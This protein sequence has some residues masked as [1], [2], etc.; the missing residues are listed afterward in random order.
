[1]SNPAFILAID[2]GTTGSAAAVVDAQGNVRSKVKK[3]YRQIFPK[4]GWVEHDPED[5]WSSV[6]DTVASALAQAKIS[7]RDIAA[8]GITN[9][10]E[11]SILWDRKSGRAAA[12]AIVWQDRRTADF[13]AG[14]KK[15]GLE[16][17]FRH[18]TG[19]LLDPYFSG[20][21]IRWLLDHVPGLRAQAK[22]RDIAFGT[23]DSFLLWRLTGGAVHATDVSNA[24]RTLLMDLKTL[25]WDADLCA[26]MRVP[27]NILPRIAPSIGLFGKTSNVPGLPDDIP[28]TA[29]AG[30]QQAALFGQACFDVGEA[31]CT[32]GTGSFLLLNIGSKPVL[33]RSGCVTTVAWQWAGKTTY[34]LEGSAFVCG[35]AVQWLR[36]GLGLIAASAE[37]ESLATSVGDCGGVYFVPALAGLGAPHWNPDARGLIGGLTR[38]TTKAHVARATLEG[39]ALQNADLLLAMQKDTKKKIK[40]LKVDGGAAVNDF[41]MQMQADFLGVS[42]VRP[43]VVETTSAGAAFMA[44]LGAGVWKDFDE[45]RR[46]WKKDRQFNPSLSPKKRA[47]RLHLWQE[48][49]LRA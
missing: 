43:Q 7:G 42:C 11:T 5:I 20:T 31:K 18:K 45:I 4:P 16:K 34:A 25:A 28:I 41:L 35:A 22:K 39:I 14:L 30:D 40:S 46:V 17:V 10:R 19:L 6:L 36:D 32:F 47:E 37:M 9:Q 38:G 13:C 8:I 44:G 24:S 23:V 29:M 33:S 21:K 3:E 15:A 26:I 27:M 2:Q 49:V 12:N 1:M 48:Q